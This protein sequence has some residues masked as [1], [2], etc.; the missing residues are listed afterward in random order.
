MMRRQMYFNYLVLFS[1]ETIKTGVSS[2]PIHRLQDYC[3]EASSHHLKVIDFFLTSPTDKK[4]ALK[5]ES[6][7]CKFYDYKAINGHRERFCFDDLDEK[8]AIEANGKFDILNEF[9]NFISKLE[10]EWCLKNKH[11]ILTDKIMSTEH[12]IKSLEYLK[13]ESRDMAL[14]GHK[15]APS[16][17]NWAVNL[18]CIGYKNAA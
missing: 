10:F 7:L 18:C 9:Q 6:S 14:Y 17:F 13:R 11:R 4:T 8:I 2:K 16:Y 3:Q 5:V 1:D 12:R 15:P